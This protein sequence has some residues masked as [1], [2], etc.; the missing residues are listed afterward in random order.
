[1]L[2][3]YL[4]NPLNFKALKAHSRV[5]TPLAV[6]S[7]A[8]KTLHVLTTATDSTNSDVSSKEGTMTVIGAVLSTRK[9]HHCGYYKFTERRIPFS[10]AK[11]H[12]QTNIMFTPARDFLLETPWGCISVSWKS[13]PDIENNAT[14]PFAPFSYLHA[15]SGGIFDWSWKQWQELEER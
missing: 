3:N 5:Y 12:W 1:M 4:V 15:G 2:F 10:P 6:V 11:Q 9:F 14:L 8:C 13:K 7:R